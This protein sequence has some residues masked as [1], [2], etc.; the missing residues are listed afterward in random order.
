MHVEAVG[1]FCVTTIDR[2]QAYRDKNEL[3]DRYRY[4]N[5]CRGVCGVR[6]CWRESMESRSLAL[7]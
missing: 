4:R 3:R 2:I 7:S 1:A 6:T 5:R